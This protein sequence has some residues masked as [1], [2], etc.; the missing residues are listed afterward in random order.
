M[1]EER[2]F[3]CTCGGEGITFQVD[4]DGLMLAMWRVGGVDTGWRNRLR[5][6][7]QIIKRGH[8]YTDDMILDWDTAWIFDNRLHDAIVKAQQDGIAKYSA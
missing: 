7:W 1:S 2:L 8:P 6:I 3:L 5:H 4:E